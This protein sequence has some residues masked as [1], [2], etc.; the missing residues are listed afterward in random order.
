M[1]QSTVRYDYGFGVVGESRK[2]GARRAKPGLLNSTDA[3][4][5]VIGRA[6]TLNGD[7]KTFGAGGTGV[8]GGILSGPKQYASYGTAAGGPLAP[9]ITL[10]NNTIAELTE[11]DYALVVAMTNANVAIGDYVVFAQATG[12]LQS[13]TPGSAIPA[14]TTRILGAVVNDLPQPTANGLCTISLTGPLSGGPS[15]SD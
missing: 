7:G 6:V 11:E 2:H 14:N 1:P 13:V 8:F 3:T 5:N 9:T 10:P 15:G 12:A 4:Q